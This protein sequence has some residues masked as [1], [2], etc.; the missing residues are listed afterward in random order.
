MHFAG[1]RRRYSVPC[2][3]EGIPWR[4]RPYGGIVLPPRAELPVFRAA[5]PARLTHGIMAWPF[6]NRICATIL[7]TVR[8]SI[9]AP[10]ERRR[11]E[12]AARLGAALDAAGEAIVTLDVEGRIQSINRPGLDMFGADR[13]QLVG[14]GIWTLFGEGTAERGGFPPAGAPL[15]IVAKRRTGETFSAKVTVHDTAAG[16]TRIRV[17]SIVDLTKSGRRPDETARRGPVDFA[18]RASGALL[19]EINQPLAATAAYLTVARKQLLKSAQINDDVA[20]VLASASAQTLRA[21]RLVALL[22]DVLNQDD[23]GTTTFSL[24]EKIRD[25]ID[26][27]RASGALGDFEAELSLHARSDAITADRV[28]IVLALRDIL[29]DA[30]V[31]IGS[32]NDRS[33]T[34][35]TTNPDAGT[36]QVDIAET[37]A[38]DLDDASFVHPDAPAGPGA[39]SLGSTLSL[40]A[41]VIDEH[42]GSFLRLCDGS[43]RPLLRFTLPLGA[44]DRTS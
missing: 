3:G 41:S 20:S 10:Q 4:R 8:A 34:I 44:P 21:S 43:G 12:E 29:R 22:R 37:G 5:R 14:A 16:K 35:R 33:L 11:T 39:E 42:K 7:T 38:L 24:H 28:Q 15:E 26:E 1:R 40:S 30:V 23:A 25:A 18:N 6:L 17:V 27:L 19:H 32:A 9:C 13:E 31:A 2:A 36:L